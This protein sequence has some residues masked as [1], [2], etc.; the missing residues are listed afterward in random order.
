MVKTD[1]MLA[2]DILR[3]FVTRAAKAARSKDHIA[4]Q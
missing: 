2:A 4:E 3:N 1:V